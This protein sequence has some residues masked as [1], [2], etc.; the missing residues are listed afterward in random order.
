MVDDTPMMVPV[1]DRAPKRR[2]LTNVTM[3]LAGPT[4]RVPEDG[5]VQ[6]TGPLTV[7]GETFAQ[8]LAR[9]GTEDDET[10]RAVI[11]HTDTREDT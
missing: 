1:K 2:R 8:A 7:R 11:A 3:G 5:V 4:D 9:Q 10:L 6:S